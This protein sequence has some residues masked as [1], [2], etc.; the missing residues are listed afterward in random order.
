VN[1]WLSGAERIPGPH[2]N[3]LSMDGSAGKFCTHHITVTPKGSY[4]GV[5]GALIREGYEPTLLVDPVLGRIGQFFP[6]NR[7]GYALEHPSGTPTTN[8]EGT[9]HV[10]IEWVWPAMW[11][12][13]HPGLDITH[14]KHFAWCWRQVVVFTRQLGIPDV[15]PFGFHST[16]RDVTIWRTSGHR[17]HVNAPHNSHV[18]N[19]PAAKAPAWPVPLHPLTH[20]HRLELADLTDMFD[21]RVHHRQGLTSFD[22]KHVQAHIDAA[23]AALAIKEQS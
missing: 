6:A 10:Q 23:R 11:R 17:G 20:Q 4:D 14:A 21:A 18:D 3:G 19:L 15:W 13:F 8:T 7:A 1:L 9:V 2:A 16:S 22:R 12:R 5:K